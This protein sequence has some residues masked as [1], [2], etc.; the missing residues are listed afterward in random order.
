MTATASDGTLTASQSFT[1]TVIDPSRAPV[2]TNP[3]SQTSAEGTA[4]SLQVSASDPDA[5]PLAFSASGLPAD[6]TIGPATGLITGALSFASAGTYAVTVTA[7]DGTF[8]TIQSFTW[9]V[10]NTDRAPVLANPGDQV[11][12]DSAGYAQGVVSDVP[13]QYLRLGQ[14]GGAAAE[15]WSGYGRTGTYHGPVAYGQPGAI[16][17]GTTAVAFDCTDG[18]YVDAGLAGHSIR[19]RQPAPWKCGSRPRLQTTCSGSSPT[20]R[21]DGRMMLASNLAVFNGLLYWRVAD[22]TTQF[23]QWSQRSNLNDGQWHHVVCALESPLRW[24][25][26]PSVALRRRESGPRQQSP[27]GRLER[28]L[29]HSVELGRLQGAGGSGFIGALGEWAIYGYALSPAQIATHYARRAVNEPPMSLQLVASDPD[30][31]S[32]VYS[33]TGLPPALTVNPATGLISGA[34][35]FTSAGT[36]SGHGH[37]VPTAV[38]RPARRSR[39]PSRAAS[40]TRTAW[41][42]RTPPPTHWRCWPMRRSAYL[43][44]R[45]DRGHAGA[46]QRRDESRHA[47]RRYHP[48]PARRAR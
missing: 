33:A 6:L 43:A 26:R 27:G 46:R 2:V 34:L 8:E 39:G 38:S 40:P 16:A 48:G 4:V 20:T 25:A 36:P 17:H 15:D 11:N 41:R 24:H 7:S 5:D 23:F 37:G 10:T 28:H 19:N 47:L 3:G 22:G 14:P 31:D 44:T 1:W 29:T 9:T 13:V 42:T 21:A 32:L 18:A 12:E 35:D 30:G 45:R